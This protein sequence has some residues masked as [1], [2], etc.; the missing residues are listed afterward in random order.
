MAGFQRILKVANDQALPLEIQVSTYRAWIA[1]YPEEPSIYA[2]LVNLLI[3]RRQF[4]EASDEIA[5]YKR[6]FPR[7]DVF[8]LKAAALIEYRRGSAVQAVALYESSFRP[9]WP[10]ELVQSYFAMLSAAHQQRTHA[11]GRTGEADC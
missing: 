8:P 7:D 9:L 4:D 3:E 10:P 11:V 5:D 6:A 1:R 2:S